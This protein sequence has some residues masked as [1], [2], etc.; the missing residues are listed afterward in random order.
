MMPTTPPNLKRRS[1]ADLLPT[2][3][4]VEGG[5]KRERKPGRRRIT[6][7]SLT[8]S[9]L[10][11]SLIGFCWL[12]F[13]PVSHTL[14]QTATGTTES[15]TTHVSSLTSSR[16]ELKIL[17]S[18]PLPSSSFNLHAYRAVESVL[19]TYPDAIIRVLTLGP[20]YASSFQ[21]ADILPRT[22]L[23]KYNKR[24]YDIAVRLVLGGPLLAKQAGADLPGA[25][26]FSRNRSARFFSDRKPIPEHQAKTD[27]LPDNSTLLFL[28]MLELYKTGGIYGDMTL[29]HSKPLQE[30]VD[31]FVVG[32][33]GEFAASQR[34][35]TCAVATTRGRLSTPILMQWSKPK[36]PV[37]GCA[38]SEFDNV[39][40]K[41]SICIRSPAG[42][43]S[44]N[45]GSQCVI[46]LL[47]QCLESVKVENKLAQSGAVDWMGCDPA[48]AEAAHS[49]IGA[50]ELLKHRSTTASAF[51]MGPPA[52]SGLWD[53]PKAG[54]VLANAFSELKLEKWAPE[55][56]DPTCQTTCSRYDTKSYT[57]DVATKAK[58]AF[59]CAPTVFVPGTQKG[60][61]TFLFHA[62]AWHPQFLQPLRG[63]HNFKET[64]R[65]EP[66][67]GRGKNKAGV[68]MAAFPFIEEHE[69][70]V[71]GDGSVSYM[72][73]NKETPVLIKADNPHAKI[74]FALRNPVERAWSDYR[75]LWD[76]YLRK[77]LPFDE[78]TKSSLP[79][80]SECI[81]DINV[82]EEKDKEAILRYYKPSC[83]VPTDASPKDPGI[84]IKKGLYYYQIL[85]WMQIFG[86]ENVMIVESDDLRY[87]QKETIEGVY[88]FLGLCPVDVSK[89]PDENITTSYAI[90]ANMQMSE[91]AYKDLQAFFE[92]YNQKLYKLIGRDL[93]WGASKF[94][95]PKATPPKATKAAI[96]SKS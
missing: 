76:H 31:G 53:A 49:G 94:K 24:G 92:P 56:I 62:I 66:H 3:A 73:A 63:A 14:E 80:V 82:P 52:T 84:L 15:L 60:A 18:W 45:N 79:A 95:P 26:W 69:N 22:L 13:S 2:V 67:I 61:S 78:I 59:H 10:L 75:F 4:S 29:F 33:E 34:R 88:K 91:A 35:S 30:G 83:G 70:F 27:A 25:K 32:G 54:S 46:D 77:N 41:V 51:W 85:H 93:G 6:S 50:A 1:N 20:L 81:G 87:R 5:R 43:T 55:Q 48:M 72:F 37:L 8:T 47:T 42:D 17:L 12:R 64:G 71:T 39:N 65:Y 89:L 19:S 36:H 74:V 57:N 90:P 44:P 28:A 68:R 38:L 7:L 40:S 9:M 21:Y 96:K 11:L 86:R 23:Q 58:A 16:N